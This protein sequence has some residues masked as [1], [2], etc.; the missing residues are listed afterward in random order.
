MTWQLVRTEDRVARN[1]R[2]GLRYAMEDYTDIRVM[3]L[4]GLE[5]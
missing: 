2:E 3:V 5:L 1:G 4:T